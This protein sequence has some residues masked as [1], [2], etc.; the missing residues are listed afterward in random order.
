MFISTSYL[1]KNYGIEDKIARFFVDREPPADNLYWCGKLLYLRSSPGYL[2]IPLIV[3]LLF[4]IGIKKEDLLSDKFV[5]LM[6]DVGHVSALEETNEI[7][8]KEAIIKCTELAVNCSNQT[9]L[10]NVL[11]YFSGNKDNAFDRLTTPFKALHRGDFFLFSLGALQFEEKLFPM[12]ARVWFALISTL[13]L[14]D[15]AE[16]ISSDKD[17]GERN[18]FIEKLPDGKVVVSGRVNTQNRYN[19]AAA[20]RTHASF[21][22]FW[23]AFFQV[24]NCFGTV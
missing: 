4:K 21:Q 20:H 12:V 24:H 8:E 23:R 3:D 15:D 2:F 14:L 7:T 9:W 13:L 22:H 16:D 18:A 5:I 11:S 19:A 6:E 1:V 10:R 17:A